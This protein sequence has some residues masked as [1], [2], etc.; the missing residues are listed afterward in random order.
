M[1]TFICM[2]SFIGWNTHRASLGD[3][4]EWYTRFQATDDSGTQFNPWGL[5]SPM[6]AEV[7]SIVKDTEHYKFKVQYPCAK[8]F[9][10]VPPT[11][12]TAEE[13]VA[14]KIA[15][16]ISKILDNPNINYAL[17]YDGTSA[18]VRKA[19]NP[20]MRQTAKPTARVTLLFA[21]AS[22]EAAKYGFKNSVQPGV[23]ES[24]NEQIAQERANRVGAYLMKYNIPVDSIRSE[25]IQFPD[26]VEANDAVLHPEKLNAMR[27]V[28]ANVTTISERV[29]IQTT[30]APVIFPLWLSLLTFG[31]IGLWKLA[32]LLYLLRKGNTDPKSVKRSLRYFFIA[33]RG[34]CLV[35]IAGVVLYFVRDLLAALLIIAV[36]YF[37]LFRAYYMASRSSTVFSVIVLFWVRIWEKIIS[38]CKKICTFFKSKYE[39]FCACWKAFDA[40][41]CWKRQFKTLFAVCI[42]LLATV[43]ILVILLLK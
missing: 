37:V 36:I 15:Y 42:G 32:N 16:E 21:T 27:Y 39:T 5:L 3:T 7:Q 25:E 12:A 2:F 22:P 20:K 14:K 10:L 18:A 41:P 19:A 23:F 24:E 9:V 33:V 35:L 1:A 34:V 4:T 6:Q 26:T 29:V 11:D 28:V 8:K 31:I 38:L 30:T 13:N 40:L 43:I 17:D